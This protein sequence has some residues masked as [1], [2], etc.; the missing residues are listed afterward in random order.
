MARMINKRDSTALHLKMARRHMRLCGRVSDT[1]KLVTDMQAVWNRLKEK[2]R[3]KNDAS[4]VRDDAY[5]DVR[6]CDSGLDNAVRT[7]F[8]RTRQYDRDNMTRMLDMLFPA[9]GFSTLVNMPLYKE[10]QEVSKLILKLETLEE[11]HPL[12]EL[13]DLLKSKI[14]AS[15]KAWDNYQKTILAL[16][17]IQ[18]GEELAKLAVRQQYE[19][20]WLDARKSLGAAAAEN[21]FPR[22]SAK[23]SPKQDAEEEQED[24]SDE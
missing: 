14:E 24:N 3:E 9:R 4:D 2:E 8:E 5:D 20:N 10:P 21:L 1:G 19:H 11:S 15:E 6:L 12:R 13:I 7:T 16:Q 18:T 22:V 17:K 23:S